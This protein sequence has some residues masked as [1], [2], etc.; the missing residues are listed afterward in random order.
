MCKCERCE[1]EGP[2]FDLLQKTAA[3][4]PARVQN[5]K[6]SSS[7]SLPMEAKHQ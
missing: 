7:E 5:V 6:T 2:A 3:K 4:R 1:D